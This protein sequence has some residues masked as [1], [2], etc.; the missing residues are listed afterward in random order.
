V[1]KD[2]RELRKSMKAE[3]VDELKFNEELRGKIFKQVRRE[4]MKKNRRVLGPILSGAFTL[5]VISLFIF[6]GGKEIGFFGVNNNADSGGLFRYEAPEEIK[7]IG[8]DFKIP[9]QLPFK[10][11]NISTSTPPTQ[12]QENKIVTIDF[13]G[14]SGQQLSARL[15][16][17]EEIKTDDFKREEVKIGDL[18]GSY[19][20]NK[21]NVQILSWKED[22]KSYT[23]FYMPSRS[24][25]TNNVS[26]EQMVDT[27]KTFDFIK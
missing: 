11:E 8:K 7:E 6:L 3:F 16:S 25:E 9:T 2:L 12:N 14:E 10:P 17:T 26:K 1:D 18:I 15:T 13:V 24:K 22:N 27:A 21:N 4:K 5:L 23:L 19:G 20:I